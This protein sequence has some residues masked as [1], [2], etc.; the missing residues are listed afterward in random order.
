MGSTK[1]STYKYTGFVNFASI[2]KD[3]EHKQEGVYQ[4]SKATIYF[5]LEKDGT[6]SDRW[7]ISFYKNEDNQDKAHI[8]IPYVDHQRLD[9][10]T[11]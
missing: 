4:H 11:T 6:D 8:S 5:A 7:R 3:K 9:A 2:N 1:F 10:N